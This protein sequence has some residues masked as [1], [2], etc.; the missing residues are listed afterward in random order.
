MKGK[1]KFLKQA[2]TSQKHLNFYIDD[3]NSIN[4]FNIEKTCIL[5]KKKKF[6]L[7]FINL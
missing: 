5:N 6:I 3:L 1:E 4:N 2:R 7:K